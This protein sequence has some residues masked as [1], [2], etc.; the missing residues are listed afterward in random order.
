MRIHRHPLTWIL[1]LAF[2]LRA[3]LGLARPFAF[4]DS[5]DYLALAHNLLHG[6]PYALPSGIATR[7]PG[8]P[9]LIAALGGNLHLLVL[10]QAAMGAA[11]VALTYLL[12][13]DALPRPTS[14]LPLL[15]AT[16][17]A[18]DPLSIGFAAAYLTEVPYTLLLLT[19]LYLAIRTLRATQPW[20]HWTLLALTL[21]AAVYLRAS[22]LYLMLPLAL[23]ILY[24]RRHLAPRRA[25]LG[26]AAVIA[27]VLMALLPW[28]LRNYAHFHSGFFRLTTLEGISLYESV[29]PD[30][31]GGPR[32]HEL[33]LPPEIQS[34]PEAQRNDALSRLAWSHIRQDPLRIA[35]L[36]VVKIARTWSPW[37]NPGAGDAFQHWTIQLPMTLWHSIAYA[38][39]LLGLIV[40]WRHTRPANPATTPALLVLLLPLGYFTALHA[41]FLGSVRYRV[42][43]MPLVLLFSAVGAACLF[44]QFRAQRSR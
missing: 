36:A 2:T 8:Y 42:P 30:A 37:F 33:V 15:A 18:L 4:P 1:L 20:W 22:S 6:Q 19:A 11:T 7:M 29:Y 39:A 35:R 28:Q 16:L 5:A 10:L 34:L 12:A 3:A 26:S 14:R 32:Q 23:L 40:A 13:R 41:L 27:L 44:R 21:A 38:L 17:A 9:L 43:L 25:L 31:T 24:G